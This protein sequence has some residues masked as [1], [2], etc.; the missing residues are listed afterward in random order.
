MRL[1]NSKS[2]AMGGLLVACPTS[3]NAHL[4]RITISA[5]AGVFPKLLGGT[6][7]E[8]GAFAIDF[9]FWRA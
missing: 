7:S 3:G 2:G 6:Q 9:V 5:R 8:I 4:L 1:L